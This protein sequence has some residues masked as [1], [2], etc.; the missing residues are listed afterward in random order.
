MDSLSTPHFSNII[1]IGM[2][3]A[4]K[5]TVGAL[6][7]RRC[8][9]TFVDTDALIETRCGCSLQAYLERAGTDGLRKIEEEVLL[10]LEADELVIATGGSAIYSERGMA[11]LSQT[12]VVVLLAAR[13]STVMARIENQETRG[14]VN[15]DGTDFASLYHAR[16][17][18]Y[19]RWADWSL[20]VDHDPPGDIADKIL[21][22][23][24]HS[25]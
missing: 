1:L 14:L 7:A 19:A 22:R 2:A 23:I 5:S 24:V 10:S 21:A 20:A 8:G 11:H 16:Q 12:G 13:L 6:L 25:R 17:P 4:G 9:R 3:G 18:L 15:P